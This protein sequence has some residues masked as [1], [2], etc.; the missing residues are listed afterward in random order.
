V[1]EPAKEGAAA[2]SLAT[3]RRG[4][5]RIVRATGRVDF[6]TTPAFRDGLFAEAAAPP[7]GGGLIVDLAGVE[8]I[9]SAGLRV[10]LQARNLAT[11][12]GAA[13]VVSGVAG[14]VADVFRVSRFDTLLTVAP[15]LGDAVAR[16]APGADP[17]AGG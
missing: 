7:A 3:E 17:A 6:A 9:T 12:A 16:L 5:L 1:S 13:M 14:T 4:A 15:T 8:L 2:L 10:L 11:E